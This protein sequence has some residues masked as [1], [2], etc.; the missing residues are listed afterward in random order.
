MEDNAFELLEQP[1]KQRLADQI[2]RQI[3]KLIFSKNIEVG[4]KLPTERDLAAN[5]KVSR[6]VVREA[7]R[8]LEQSGFIEIR[9]GHSG[10]S[11]VS[12]KAYKPFFDS[13]Y[14]LF[15]D[16]KLNLH[17]FYQAREAM[18]R[19]SVQLAMA[20]IDEK[21]M[22]E[23][24]R[25][26]ETLKAS[27]FSNETFH[28]NNMAFHMKIADLSQNPLI[29]LIV[30]ALLSLLKIV[31]PEPCQSPDFIN[32]TYERHTRI[33]EAMKEKDVELVMN[34]IAEDTSFTG[35]LNGRFGLELQDPFHQLSPE[36]E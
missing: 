2:A 4:Q 19:F 29:K 25:I 26:N 30:G 14:D 7:L 23:L 9:P 10:G 11:Y 34:L 12:N 32:A 8:S 16:G 5:L 28:E 20:N 17:H 21:G 33:I 31:L 22:E 36:K 24:V 1:V 27:A 15:E 35:K 13:I 6:V 3:K 18:E